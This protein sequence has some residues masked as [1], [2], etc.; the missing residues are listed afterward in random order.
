MT[1]LIH[2]VQKGWM[3][4]SSSYSHS[5][6]SQL[7][8]WHNKLLCTSCSKVVYQVAG[9]RGIFF[10]NSGTSGWS[11]VPKDALKESPEM[12]LTDDGRT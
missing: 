10:P 8:L 6:G 12:F 11:N 1:L 7:P 9:E 2:S 4:D 3:G 5:K